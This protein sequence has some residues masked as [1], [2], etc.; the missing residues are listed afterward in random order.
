M[1]KGTASMDIN[2]ALEEDEVKNGYILSCQ[3]RPTGD[4]PWVAD[5]DQQ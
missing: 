4:G 5:F 1:D 2:Y 3:A